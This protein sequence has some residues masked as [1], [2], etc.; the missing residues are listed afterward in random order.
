M[1]AFGDDGH[2]KGWCLFMMGCK[3][4]VTHASCSTRH[5]N[6][7]P[8]CWPIGIGAPCYGC[9]EKEVAFRVP[10]FDTVRPHDV[11]PPSTYAPVFTEQGEASRV[12]VALGGAVVGAVVGA[13][14]VASQKVGKGDGPGSG[15]TRSRK[16]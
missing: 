3:G 12:A 7:T 15:D 5:F 10:L 8:D 4:P 13:G 16:E 11:V 1:R 14:L 9:T 2:R 6:E